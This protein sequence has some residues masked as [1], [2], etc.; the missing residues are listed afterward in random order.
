MCFSD[1][2]H[3][4]SSHLCCFVSPRR[5]RSIVRTSPYTSTPL[6]GVLITARNRSCGKIRSV[7]RLLPCARNF[8]IYLIPGVPSASTIPATALQ[9]IQYYIPWMK[10][11]PTS[12]PPFSCPAS[13]TAL[14]K[15]HPVL[16]LKCPLACRGWKSPTLSPSELSVSVIMMKLMRSQLSCPIVI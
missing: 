4:C 14:V 3:S 6:A 2:Q 16:M 15:N 12:F 5:S 7:K 8:Y 1:R 9:I 13:P 10:T 11:S